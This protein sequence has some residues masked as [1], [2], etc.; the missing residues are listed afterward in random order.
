[1]GLSTLLAV[2]QFEVVVPI[3]TQ[4]PDRCY[5]FIWPRRSHRE[6]GRQEKYG[7]VGNQAIV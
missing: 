3:L 6:S 7:G 1:M 2:S 4:D 5:L